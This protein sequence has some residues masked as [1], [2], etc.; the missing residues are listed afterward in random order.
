MAAQKNDQYRRDGFRLVQRQSVG[1]RELVQGTWVRTAQAL[2]PAQ[3]AMEECKAQYGG[4]IARG[5]IRDQ[6]F[7]IEA[8]FK[9]LHTKMA[10][11]VRGEA[12]SYA[13]V[14]PRKCRRR[15][16]LPAQKAPPHDTSVQ[17]PTSRSLSD[18]C[19][20]AG[21]VKAIARM[22]PRVSCSLPYSCNCEGVKPAES[23][24]IFQVHCP[25]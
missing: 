2:S 14:G 24:T 1:G 15:G 19:P 9:N 7:Y 3:L 21:N 16:L 4:G 12:G 22:M 18:A 25:P 6:W 5:L 23:N 8:C 10:S 13:R 20:N 17:V 11:L